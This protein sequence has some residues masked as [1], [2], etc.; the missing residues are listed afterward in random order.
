MT[1]TAFERIHGAH[2]IL[3]SQ[4]EATAHDQRSATWFTRTQLFEKLKFV[5]CRAREN[6]FA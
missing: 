6:N 1:C 4:N 2:I 5:L 3:K